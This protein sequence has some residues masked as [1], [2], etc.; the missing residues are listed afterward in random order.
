MSRQAPD[1]NARNIC[2]HLMRNTNNVIKVIVD[3]FTS[4]TEGSKVNGAA[5]NTTSSGDI[6]NLPLKSTTLG[7]TQ[8]WGARTGLGWPVVP[9]VC[10]R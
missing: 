4:T 10:N 7:T 6:A 8:Q 1:D 5:L 2:N 9:V 3:G